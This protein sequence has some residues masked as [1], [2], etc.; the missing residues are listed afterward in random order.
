MAENKKEKKNTGLIIIIVILVMTL[1]GACGYKN[2]VICYFFILCYNK[3]KREG[4][5]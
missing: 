2:S 1:L 5:L 3:P 4:F